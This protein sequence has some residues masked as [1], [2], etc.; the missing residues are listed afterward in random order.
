LCRA[1]FGERG[2]VIPGSFHEVALLHRREHVHVL[3]VDVFGAGREAKHEKSGEN[4]TKR[5]PGRD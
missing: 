4:N 1:I 5:D 2:V 3:I